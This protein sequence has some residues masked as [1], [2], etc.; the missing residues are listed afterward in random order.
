MTARAVL[1]PADVPQAADAL[2]IGVPMR[3]RSAAELPELHA[4]WTA[5]LALGVIRIREGRA[6]RGFDAEL[7]ERDWLVA[8][9]AVAGDL[10]DD[11]E[12]DDATRICRRTLHELDDG[13]PACRF[14]PALLDLLH[15]FGAIDEEARLTSLGT[16]AAEHLMPYHAVDLVPAHRICLLR[17]TL[18]Y[19]RPS[20]WRKILVPATFTLG[21][22]HQIVQVAMSWDEDAPHVFTVGRR[23]FDATGHDDISI[24][25]AFTVARRTVVY[26]FGAE[27]R[28]EI[29]LER[30]E[31]AVPGQQYP[32]CVA[33][34]SP[35]DLDDVNRELAWL[36]PK[37]ELE[38]NL[39]VALRRSG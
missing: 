9:A 30:V 11:E 17:I 10:L 20:C 6:T 21:Y 33:S 19:V 22:V 26:D 24:G 4:P 1:R 23:Q 34:A 32:Y 5:A 27:Y 14:D 36:T 7:D 35:C 37:P 39:G 25:E 28:H 8:L 2:G 12:G 3:I 16:V 29:T 38:I 18:R 15:D 31:E 13:A